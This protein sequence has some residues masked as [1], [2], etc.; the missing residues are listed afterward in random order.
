VIDVNLQIITGSVIPVH[1]PQ[2]KKYG[3]L[4]WT[5]KSGT[6]LCRRL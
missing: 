6:C 2:G 5:G 4:S 1:L 3:E